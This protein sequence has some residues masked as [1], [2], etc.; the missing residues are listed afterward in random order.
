MPCERRYGVKEKPTG[1]GLPEIGTLPFPAGRPV[2]PE[3]G[4]FK[5]LPAAGDAC[6]GLG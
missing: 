6:K 4:S 5:I 3:G 1:S 2:P